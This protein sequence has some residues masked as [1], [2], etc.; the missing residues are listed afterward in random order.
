MSKLATAANDRRLKKYLAAFLSKRWF[1]RNSFCIN[2]NNLSKVQRSLKVWLRD[3]AMILSVM[4]AI[5]CAAGDLRAQAQERAPESAQAQAAPSALKF[6]S[7]TSMLGYVYGLRPMLDLVGEIEIDATD[8]PKN[9]LNP[10]VYRNSLRELAGYQYLLHALVG[11]S[12]VEAGADLGW[13]FVTELGQQLRH[14]GEREVAAYQKL[15]P[16]EEPRFEQILKVEILSSRMLTAGESDFQRDAFARERGLVQRKNI[17]NKDTERLRISSAQMQNVKALIDS[18]LVSLSSELSY[19]EKSTAEFQKGF[20]LGLRRATKVLQALGVLGESI[21]PAH[22][23]SAHVGV[24]SMNS[25]VKRFRQTLESQICCE[26]APVDLPHSPD[27]SVASS[28]AST[29]GQH[30]SRQEG[31]LQVAQNLVNSLKEFESK[32]AGQTTSYRSQFDFLGLGSSYL[33]SEILALSYQKQK[34]EGWALLQEQSRFLD[35]VFQ[36]LNFTEA[37]QAPSSQP[38][39][40]CRQIVADVEL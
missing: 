21:S 28:F 10:K 2:K 25:W 23:V 19:Q 37:I 18:R 12:L 9:S 4:A 38:P 26:P 29:L 24:V 3:S 35:S 13:G 31:S 30:Q 5:V 22:V 7:P 8:L 1:A 34:A 27:T 20:V 15:H 14:L 16:R 32:F 6:A 33:F 17:A 40:L 11:E 36:N 39:P